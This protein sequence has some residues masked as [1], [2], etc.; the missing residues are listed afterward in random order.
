LRYDTYNTVAATF[1]DSGAFRTN[2]YFFSAQG[3]LRAELR[4]YGTPRHGEWAD[5][6]HVDGFC[7]ERY[8]GSR[9]LDL[10]C[11]Q[12][13]SLRSL[14]YTFLNAF[15]NEQCAGKCSGP[16]CQDNRWVSLRYALS[17]G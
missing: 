17:L 6:V 13:L 2:L 7:D 14:N 16:Q 12:R 8:L 5:G 11:T 3:D 15:P 9:R 10:K 4:Q 1:G